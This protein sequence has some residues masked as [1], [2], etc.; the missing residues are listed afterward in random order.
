MGSNLC[1]W[2]W[3]QARVRP[4]QTV[5]VVASRS[6]TFLIWNSSGIAPP[7]LVETWLRLNPVAMTWSVVGLGSMSPA[8]CSIVNRS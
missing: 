5:P 8:S 1:S 2:Q 3:A 7:S 4:I 6:A